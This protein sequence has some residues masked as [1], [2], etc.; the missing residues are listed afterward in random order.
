MMKQQQVKPCSLSPQNARR[1][2]IVQSTKI[3][4][5]AAYPLPGME[6]RR[7]VLLLVAPLITEA[8]E[9][10]PTYQADANLHAARLRADIMA[11]SGYDRIVP[12]TSNREASGSDFSDSGTDVSLQVRFF[13]VQAVKAAEG[14]MQLKVWM[15]MSWVDTRLAWNESE[16][17]GITKT[18]FQGNQFSGAEESELWVPDIQPYNSMNGLVHTL[19]PALARVSSDG[20]V[21]YSRPGSLN[22]M[23]KFSGLVAFPFDTLKCT[24][25]FGGWIISGGNQGIKLMGLGYQFSSQEATSGSSYQEYQISHVNATIVN[26]EYDCCPSEPWPVVLYTVSLGRASLFYFTVTI[27]PGILITLLS[28]AVF[29]T[30]TNSADALSYGIT[31][32]VVNLL[33]SIVL[34]AML[35]ICGELI[36]ID[37]FALTNTAFCCISLAQSAFNIM[38][39]NKDDD[40]LLPA[41]LVRGVT[42]IACLPCRLRRLC[43]RERAAVSGTESADAS[44]AKVLTSADV[45]LP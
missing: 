1:G 19:D 8:S 41:W 14:S 27:I 21:F 44:N 33:S 42:C 6:V 37:I 12:P 32:I 18:F 26:Y 30:D 17:G 22:V 31:V 5:S 40:H 24:I 10:E 13:K 36:W 28:F 25:E 4:G 15:R 3:I 29:W 38:L 34:L 23:C 35:P 16:Y 9:F 11:R 39:E 7:L 43:C 45:S 20:T 2:W